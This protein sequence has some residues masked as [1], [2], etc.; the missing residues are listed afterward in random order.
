MEVFFISNAT[1]ELYKMFEDFAE[2]F[3]QTANEYS[4]Q[5]KTMAEEL[6]T[7]E[8]FYNTLKKT[9]EW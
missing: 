7:S 1:L 3:Y 5:I 2:K 9:H 4:A 8:K 6:L